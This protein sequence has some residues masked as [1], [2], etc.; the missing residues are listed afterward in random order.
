MRVGE[1]IEEGMEAFGVGK[2]RSEH[3][4]RV[5]GIWPERKKDA[6]SWAGA[7]SF[8]PLPLDACTL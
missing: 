5:E 2:N 7:D 6:Y 8:L 1:I 4:E 3:H